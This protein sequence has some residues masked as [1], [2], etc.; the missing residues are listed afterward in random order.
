MSA[1]IRYTIQDSWLILRGEWI[2]KKTGSGSAQFPAEARLLAERPDYCGEEFSF[3]DKFIAAKARDGSKPGNPK[4]WL[5]AGINYHMTLT[6][7]MIQKGRLPISRQAKTIPAG[8]GEVTA[9]K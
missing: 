1:S 2:G 8:V 6:A 5:L 4:Q 3:G 7:I 9:V